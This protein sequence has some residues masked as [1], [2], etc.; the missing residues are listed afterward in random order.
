VTQCYDVLTSTV[1]FVCICAVDRTVPSVKCRSTR[2][3]RFIIAVLVGVASVSHARVTVGRC[4][5]VTGAWNQCVYVT[6][7][8]I[9]HQ[10]V[11]LV[12]QSAALAVNSINVLYCTSWHIS[13]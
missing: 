11:Y 9:R 3:C 2:S 5:S 10:D 13:T 6:A 4:R 1:Q 12:C 7:V 8:M